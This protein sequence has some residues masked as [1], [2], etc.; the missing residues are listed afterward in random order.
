M[1]REKEISEASVCGWVCFYFPER[2]LEG[3]R[4]GK[5]VDESW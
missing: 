3:C 5:R 2:E 4:E 1:N